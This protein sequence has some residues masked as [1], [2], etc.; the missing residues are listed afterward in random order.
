M[1]EEEVVGSVEPC[2]C[3]WKVGSPHKTAPHKDSTHGVGENFAD[4]PRTYGEVEGG[5]DQRPVQAW[6]TG[7]HNKAVGNT[8]G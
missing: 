4:E 2:R 6:L 5:E 3:S 1:D 8:A 7:Q